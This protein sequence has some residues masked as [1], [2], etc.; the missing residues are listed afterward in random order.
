VAV[1]DASNH[2][3]FRNVTVGPRDGELWVI[4][5]GLQ[6]DDRVVA[7]GIQAVSDKM[8]VRARPMPAPNVPEAEATSGKNH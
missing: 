4:E 1:V 5:Q 2:V 8:L 3:S 6:P 7:E